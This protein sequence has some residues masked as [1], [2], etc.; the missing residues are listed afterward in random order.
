MSERC[1][2]LWRLHDDAAELATVEEI[3][4]NKRGVATGE[5][6]RLFHCRDGGI[7]FTSAPRLNAERGKE[8][9]I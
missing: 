8:A 5:T 3:S 4:L 1:E 9:E 2:V 7:E 6:K